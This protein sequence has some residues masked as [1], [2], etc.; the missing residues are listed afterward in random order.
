MIN[1][2]VWVARFGAVI[3]WYSY[4]IFFPLTCYDLIL[5]GSMG[6]GVDSG[7]YESR[8]TG[9]SDATLLADPHCYFFVLVFHAIFQQG[10]GDII[11]YPMS[12]SRA[13]L[14]AITPTTKMVSGTKAASCRRCI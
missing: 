13:P 7:V 5:A 3:W 10:A 1:G 6:G 4:L 11:I 9:R 8:S 12:F 2:S 14:S